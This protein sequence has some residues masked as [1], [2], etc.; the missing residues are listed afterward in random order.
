[1]SREYN[2]EDTGKLV[3]LQTLIRSKDLSVVQFLDAL[4]EFCAPPEERD[5]GTDIRQHPFWDEIL[6]Q[7]PELFNMPIDK[8]RIKI[9][10]GGFNPLISYLYDCLYG[11]MHR[12]IEE[13]GCEEFGEEF[14]DHEISIQ[15]MIISKL[16]LIIAYSLGFKDC[17]HGEEFPYY[18]AWDIR[19]F[20]KNMFGDN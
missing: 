14:F 9:G 16:I 20:L 1:M 3:P 13:E 19:K 4:D 11:T 18:E 5:E 8:L 17:Q 12:A 2:Y 6:K 10:E 15:L 7:Y